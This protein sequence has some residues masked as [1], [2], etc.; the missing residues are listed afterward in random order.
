MVGDSSMQ[1]CRYAEEPNR[2][3][4][5]L[6]RSGCP[7]ADPL[8]FQLAASYYA[9]YFGQGYNVDASFIV[10]RDDV[11]L[12]V[13]RGQSVNGVLSDNGQDVSIFTAT[14]IYSEAVVLSLLKDTARWS[15]CH[16][17]RILDHAAGGVMTALG[18]ALMFYKAVPQL[19]VLAIADLTA[20]EAEL[21][22]GL[23]K[24]Y[25]SLINWGLK[26]LS[27]Q[28][29]T[30]EAFDADAFESFRQF[31]IRT[32]G[33]ETRSLKSWNLQAEMIKAN[34]AELLLSYLH[35]DQLVG[36]SLFLDT[37]ET[38]TYGVGVYERGLF[39]KP[40]SHAPV[41]MAMLRAKERGQRRFV[42]GDVPPARSVDDKEFSIGWFKSGFTANLMVGLD[43][44]YQLQGA[45]G[46]ADLDTST[47]RH[48]ASTVSNE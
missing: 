21:R 38:T 1:I 7:F 19:R 24:S 25:R 44:T 36:A 13:M 31:H 4:D 47:V 10:H 45:K 2:F 32:A 20:S 43:W 26:T 27:L 23:R 12:F 37:G 16:T 33:R 30:A 17:I 8:S 48:T 29:V 42:I 34:R 22:V 41:F 11:P 46:I 6:A 15:G 18:R 14:D 3:L 5:L 39:E 28:N 9:E 35:D 40:L